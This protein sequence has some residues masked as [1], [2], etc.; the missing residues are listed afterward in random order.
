[1]SIKNRNL[2]YGTIYRISAVD[3]S[4]LGNQYSHK[5]VD[6]TIVE[7]WKRYSKGENMR[8]AILDTGLEEE[9]LKELNVRE[10]KDWTD[11]NCMNDY[12]RHGTHIACIL[13]SANPFCPGIS[14][15]VE[16]FIQKIFNR[17]GVSY[18][19]WILDALNHILLL[20]V[21]F[22]GLSLGGADYADQPLIDKIEEV[23]SHGIVVISSAGNDGPLHGTNSHPSSMQQVISVGA[24]DNNNKIAPF[25][26]RGMTLEEQVHWST[27]T[28]LLVEGVSIASAAFQTSHH[29]YCT[30]LTGTSAGVPILTGYLVLLL[31]LIPSEFLLWYKNVAGI[32]FL[33]E[34]SCIPLQNTSIYEQG[35][36][37]F[38]FQMA[39]QKLLEMYPT[40]DKYKRYKHHRKSI[41]KQ[42]ENSWSSE[43]VHSFGIQPVIFPHTILVN[44]TQHHCQYWWPHCT[45]KETCQLPVSMKMNLLVY[46]PLSP[47]FS[48]D[49]IIW[50]ISEMES[51]NELL[52][53][54]SVE[55]SICWPFVCSLSM[56]LSRKKQ[57]KPILS[58]KEQWHE[59]NFG[60]IKGHFI[61]TL[62][63]CINHVKMKSIID[64]DWSF[65]VEEELQPSKIIL[66]D[67]FHHISYPV[68]Y[69]PNDDIRQSQRLDRFGD[70]P[71]SNFRNL[72]NKLSANSY[73]VK[74]FSLPWTR[75]EQLYKEV[76]A[77]DTVA[78][79]FYIDPEDLI[80]E[81]EVMAI[82]RLVREEGLVLVIVAEWYNWDTIND[83]KFWDTS[84]ERCWF[85]VTGGCSLHSLNLLGNQ[86]G[87]SFGDR[88]FDALVDMSHPI[89]YA[90]GNGLR[91]VQ[92]NSQ[93]LFA[94]DLVDITHLRAEQ[95]EESSAYDCSSVFPTVSLSSVTME[96]KQQDCQ[97][98]WTNQLPVFLYRK[99]GKGSIIVYG[100]SNCLDSALSEG[101]SSCVDDIVKVVNVAVNSSFV[102]LSILFPNI[103]FIERNTCF[104]TAG[105]SIGAE[106]KDLL[107]A[108][109][110]V[111]RWW[112]ANKTH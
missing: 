85:P 25:S 100:D 43:S 80:N 48:I 99:Y 71:F 4:Y 95:D 3:V 27:K 57:W 103:H 52:W 55:R 110:H 107:L 58:S 102:N 6:S 112:P 34:Q 18:T 47:M 41:W 109:S 36:G 68:A 111:V 59:R 22:V 96:E 74:L 9:Q 84:T 51:T 86:F 23:V 101:V 62:A 29:G 53:N 2:G 83:L 78:A 46:F 92:E 70:L 75:L 98:S 40:K 38:D 17:N 44:N 32:R 21:D 15:Q 50:R 11:D 14:P 37:L 31:S 77:N 1:M 105:T 5:V 88:V 69:I 73:Q 30:T 12:L 49:S 24:V 42:L 87:F 81:E 13:G 28:D 106:M 89:R 8:V 104:P 16:L 19:S 63:S 39:K 33:L 65:P 91:F 67:T 56:F 82:E 64:V 94:H 90:S 20:D 35:L 108:H 54:Y 60:R 93:V 7:F 76:H 61:V 97:V 72:F 66:W 26:S 10:M 45:F 79:L